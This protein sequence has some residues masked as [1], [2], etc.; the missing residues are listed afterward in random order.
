MKLSVYITPLLLL[1]IIAAPGCG[2]EAAG[3]TA[4]NIDTGS[5]ITVQD[6][7]MSWN[8]NG[9]TAE[10]TMSAPTTGWVAVGF[11]PSSAMKDANIIIGYIQDES[12]FISDDWGDG[13]ISHSADTDLGGSDN[14]SVIGGY[15]TDGTTEISFS[16]PLNSGDSYDKVLEEGRT[17]KVILAFGPDDG[18][19]FQGYHV[20]AET[21]E[22]E[23]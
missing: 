11:E 16:I 22:L 5:V 21:I 12:V 18:D 7:T 19:D 13:F 6:F 23:L 20:W 14:V 9:D 10:I 17:Y 8:L 3:E 2:S 15:E 4:E 1:I